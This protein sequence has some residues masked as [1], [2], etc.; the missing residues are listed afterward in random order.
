MAAA[1]KTEP[2]LHNKESLKPTNDSLPASIARSYSINDIPTDITI[3]RFSDR[4]FVGVSQ[5]NGKIGHFLSCAVE[6]SIIDGSKTFHVITLLGKRDDALIE[7]CARQINEKLYAL[8]GN[9]CG[10]LLLGMSL[11]EEGRHFTVVKAI[12][13]VILEL[14]AEIGMMS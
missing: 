4:L 14:C 6:E 1:R 2:T 7:V 8:Y 12:V 5:L 3:Q 9:G 10:S 11:L 13:N